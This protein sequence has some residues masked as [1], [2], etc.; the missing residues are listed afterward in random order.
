MIRPAWANHLWPVGA[1]DRV[2]LFKIATS[3]VIL[4]LCVVAVRKLDILC[5]H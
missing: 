3:V 2:T 4:E 5:R 1:G